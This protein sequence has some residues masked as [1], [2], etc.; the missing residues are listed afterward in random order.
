ML[1]SA[2]FFWIP[3]IARLEPGNMTSGN[4]DTSS[5]RSSSVNWSSSRTLRDAAASNLAPCS[6]SVIL[7]WASTAILRSSF[8][9][10]LLVSTFCKDLFKRCHKTP[11]KFFLDISLGINW[12]AF[13]K[14]VA[15]LVSDAYLPKRAMYPSATLK[16]SSSNICFHSFPNALWPISSICCWTPIPTPLGPVTSKSS[17]P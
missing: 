6:K 9:L 8:N 13:S 15:T 17:S 3:L 2:K 16:K 14:D 12:P 11:W 5:I 1:C 10:A 7:F 4:S